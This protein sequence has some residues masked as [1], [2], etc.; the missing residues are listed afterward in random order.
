MN[1]YLL[2]FI[3]QKDRHVYAHTHTHLLYIPENEFYHDP[4]FFDPKKKKKK[5]KRR[6]KKGENNVTCQRDLLRS[7]VRTIR[8]IV[9]LR[10]E[11][12][13]KIAIPPVGV[14]GDVS[15]SIFSIPLRD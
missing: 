2:N 9:S 5:K 14:K 8:R 11:A 7:S 6:K 13:G 15:P 12:I 10:A 4:Y 3:V 1:D